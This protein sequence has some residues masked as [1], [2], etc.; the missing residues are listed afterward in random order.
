MASESCSNSSPKWKSMNSLD[1]T[2]VVFINSFAHR[3]WTLD[4][5]V[6][7]LASNHML[8]GCVFICVFYFF[9]FQ[10]KGSTNSLELG[11][12][13]QILL[14][15]LLICIPGL[16][17]T[18][19]L[20]AIL[21]FRQRPLYD[22]QLHLHRA[23]TFDSNSLESWSSFP[24]DHAVL[25]FALATAV[26]L[27][28]RKIGWFLYVY[29]VFCISLPRIFLGIHYPSDILA[30]ALFGGALAYSA[31]WPALRSLVTRHAFR[32]QQASPG[33][34]YACFFFLAY[35]T[36]DLYDPLRGGIHVASEI[37]HAILHTWTNVHSM[38]PNIVRQFLT[39]LHV[40]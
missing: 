14:Y 40:Q 30:G 2:I 36:A 13:R 39:V 22:S 29:A 6:H 17:I 1:R 12:R 7:F 34:F 33:L 20:A 37:V 5:V 32:M 18:R 25:F 28:D 21:P 8:K 9:W 11:E 27:F 15:T 23:F 38:E 16:I 3:L 31:R 24:S 26:F 10:S 4:A 35:Q 19:T